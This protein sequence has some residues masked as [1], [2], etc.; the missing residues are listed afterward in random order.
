MVLRFSNH[1]FYAYDIFK[2]STY[3][4][5]FMWKKYAHAMKPVWT[6][7][8]VELT[9]PSFK[10]ARQ[11]PH[12]SDIYFNQQMAIDFIRE[13]GRHNMKKWV[14]EM[15][16]YLETP[17]LEYS[18]Y[19]YKCRGYG[20]THSI[21]CSYKEIGNYFLSLVLHQMRHNHSLKF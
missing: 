7:T 14:D 12:E 11:E 21:H 20:Y 1:I 6:L 13:Y 4:L 15:K 19:K 9:R 16:E 17:L 10:R 5:T 8:W 2:M 18:I 3:N